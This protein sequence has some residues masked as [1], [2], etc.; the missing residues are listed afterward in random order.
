MIEGMDAEAVRAWTELVRELGTQ[1]KLLGW[2]GIGL[3][4]YAITARAVVNGIRA[5]KGS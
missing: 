3:V 5:R 1:L 4:A 2:A